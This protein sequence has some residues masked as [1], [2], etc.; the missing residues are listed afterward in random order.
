MET[1][2]NFPSPQLVADRLAQWSFD[3]P[4]LLV[5]CRRV[6]AVLQSTVMIDGEARHRLRFSIPAL[7]RDH[8]SFALG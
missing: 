5:A 1:T 4:K 3:T 7:I 2:H 8:Q 6:G